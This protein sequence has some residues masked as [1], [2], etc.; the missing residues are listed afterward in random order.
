MEDGE[1]PILNLTDE[2]GNE[3]KFEIID[4][5]TLEDE[6]TFFVVTEATEKEVEG[7]VEIVILEV[8][9]EGEEEV[10]DTVTDQELANKVFEIFKKQQEELEESDEEE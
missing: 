1:S 3:V 8:K 2:D 4:V 7:D 6:R 10:L 5:V 9:Q